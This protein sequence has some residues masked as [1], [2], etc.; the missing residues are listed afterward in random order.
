MTSHDAV[1]RLCLSLPAVSSV[2]VATPSPAAASHPAAKPFSPPSFPP[3]SPIVGLRAASSPDPTAAASARR[4]EFASSSWDT[5]DNTY[6]TMSTQL[7]VEEDAYVAAQSGGLVNYGPAAGP[8]IYCQSRQSPPT[9][10]FSS[11]LFSDLPFPDLPFPPPHH[12][13]PPR[14]PSPPPPPLPPPI[15]PHTLVR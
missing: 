10:P 12:H 8:G 13:A 6:D 9:H 11:L 2:P 14:S 4:H 15:L 1:S 3:A 5:I 7:E